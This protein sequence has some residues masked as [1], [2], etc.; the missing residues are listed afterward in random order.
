MSDSVGQFP[1]NFLPERRIYRVSELSR[2]IREKLEAEFAD[3]WVEGEVS[4][5]REAPSGHLYFTLKDEVA[6]LRCVCFRQQARYLKFR[7][8][9]GLQ[10][11]ARGKISVYEVRGEYQLYVEHLEPQGLGAL[12]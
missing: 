9:D 1:L 6:Q 11:L 12:Q 3:I 2:F 7:P 10:V 8:E 4:N 5:L